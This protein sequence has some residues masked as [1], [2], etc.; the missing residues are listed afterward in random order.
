MNCYLCSGDQHELVSEKLRY[1][2]PAK[3]YK[4]SNCGLVFLHPTMTPEAERAFYEQEYG[5]IYSSEKGT[6]PADLFAARQ[7]DAQAYFDLVKDDIG[8][9]NNCLEIG[10]ASGYFL[11]RIKPHVRSVTGLETH[12]LLCRHCEEIGIKMVSSLS[13]CADGEFDRVFMF[14]VLEHLGDPVAYLDELKRVLADGGRIFIEV[15]NVEDILVS[16]YDI[17]AFHDYYYTPAHQFYYSEPTLRRVIEKAGFSKVE[18]KPLQRYDLSN[19]IHWMTKGRPG[20]QGELNHVFS[21]ELRSAYADSL[22]NRWHCDT[23]FA[24]VEK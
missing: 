13:E 24:V 4:C 23:L 19:H 5:E 16:V 12:N 6:T 3:A 10:A 20:G 14:F 17:P 9:D 18:I 15:P 22:M 2:S 8:P 21:E 7:G 11:D 1:E